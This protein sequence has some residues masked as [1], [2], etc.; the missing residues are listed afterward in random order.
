MIKI[1]SLLKQENFIYIYI[2]IYI[3]LIASISKLQA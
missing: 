2:Y 1:T 3:A